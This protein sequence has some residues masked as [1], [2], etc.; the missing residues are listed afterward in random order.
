MCDICDGTATID[1]YFNRMHLRIA[2]HGWYTVCV[3]ADARSPGWLYTVGLSE[4][5]GHPELVVVGLKPDAAHE[6]LEALSLGVLDGHRYAVGEI[7]DIGGRRVRFGAVHPAHLSRDLVAAWRGYYR[8]LGGEPPPLEVLQVICSDDFF[9]SCHRGGQ[10][11]L[12]RPA[13]LVGS[14]GR[15][16]TAGRKA[17]RKQ[18]RRPPKRRK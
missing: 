14:A 17:T 7:A 3:E 11:Q 4:S 1:D 18:R 6:V 5:F 2:E 12:S 8:G 9:C 10:R 13:P 15:G 16:R